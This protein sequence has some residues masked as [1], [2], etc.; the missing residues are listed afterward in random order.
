MEADV[1][2]TE[3][4]FVSG[5]KQPGMTRHDSETV[6]AVG[7]RLGVD[8]HNKSALETISTPL[9]VHNSM[10]PNGVIDLVELY[11]DC[12]G[13][14]F[15]G[16][17]RPR[18]DYI[19]YKQK[20]EERELQLQ[21]KVDAIVAE[22]L[23]DALSIKTP[24]QAVTR[25]NKLSEKHM[26]EQAAFDDEINPKVFGPVAAQHIE[27]ARLHIA[28]GDLNRGLDSIQNAKSTS[29]SSSCPSSLKKS[30]S[31][32]GPTGAAGNNSENGP[33]DDSGECDFVSKECPKCGTKN[34]KTHVTKT[35]I[36]GSCGCTVKKP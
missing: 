10:L 21:P 18:E 1:L 22:L 11:D 25:L 9:L 31:A 5:V 7:E 36:S 28:N 14:T 24:L 3:S 29:V 20:C 4:A 2:T 32:S 33:E 16:E 17:D 8:L 15:F 34:V 6:A 35:H 23:G 27:L 13:D 19:Q 12:A 26:V 30:L